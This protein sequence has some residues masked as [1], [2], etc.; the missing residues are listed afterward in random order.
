MGSLHQGSRLF[1]K[2]RLSRV[3]GKKNLEAAMPILFSRHLYVLV[4]WANRCKH[5]NRYPRC[6]SAIRDLQNA[7][8]NEAGPQTLRTQLQVHRRHGVTGA[9]RGQA[10]FMAAATGAR[11]NSLSTK[12]RVA[13]WRA[14]KKI[15]DLASKLETFRSSKSVHGVVSASWILKVIL[16]APNVSGR[17]LAEAFHLASRG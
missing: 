13:L 11:D 14:K 15:N 6:C 17:G 2:T 12:A 16:I 9:S 4:L 1:T 10:Y 3:L 5:Q 7:A 8:K